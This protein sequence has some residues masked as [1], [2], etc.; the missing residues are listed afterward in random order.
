MPLIFLL[1]KKILDHAGNVTGIKKFCKENFGSG[2][3][4]YN[5]CLLPTY[6][7]RYQCEKKL[8]IES[9]GILNNK[10]VRECEAKSKESLGIT[11][12]KST[13]PKKAEW[14]V[15]ELV[16]Y[17]PLMSNKGD[18]KPTYQGKITEVKTVDNEQYV[19]VQWSDNEGHS[20]S[21]DVA[22]N[23]PKL[24]KCGVILVGRKDCNTKA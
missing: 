16:D 18:G 19:T 20:D 15:K 1:G 4:D 7:C 11:N 22:T 8:P 5:L 2:T 6:Y 12:L 17:Q 14:K 21:A 10:C 3:D 23:S 13:K 9:Y 24:F